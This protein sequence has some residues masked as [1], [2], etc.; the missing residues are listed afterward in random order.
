MKFNPDVFGNVPA[1]DSANAAMA[2]IDALQSFRPE[3]QLAGLASAFKLAAERVGIR[4][5]DAFTVSGNLMND[6]EG[7]R[8][9]FAAVAEYMKQ[10]W[11]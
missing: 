7:R 5:T 1:R 2:V 3:V 4:P 8:P 11:K 9:E 6:V 10:E